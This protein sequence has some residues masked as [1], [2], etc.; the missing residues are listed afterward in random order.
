MNNLKKIILTGFFILSILTL[1]FF[2]S[3]NI[4]DQE[5]KIEYTGDELLDAAEKENY[6]R[7]KLNMESSETADKL[8]EVLN[9]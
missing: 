5:D 8:I 4:Q 9:K 3:V 1:L 2:V 7:D 6:V